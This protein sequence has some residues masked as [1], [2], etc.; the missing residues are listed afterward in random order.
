M[1]GLGA[2]TLSRWT[3]A[4]WNARRIE[5]GGDEMTGGIGGGRRGRNR[6]LAV[7]L[8]AALTLAAS[9]LARAADDNVFKI[10]WYETP[11]SSMG[12]AWNKAIEVWK[13]K[14]PGVTVAFEQKSWDQMEKAGALMLNSGDVPDVLEYNKGNAFAGVVASQGLLTDLTAEAAKRGWDKILTASEQALSRYDDRGI[15]GSGPL[16]GIPDYGEYVSVYYNKDM[17]KANGL[18]VPKTYDEFVKVMDA[19]VAKGITPVAEAAG[20]YP[21]VHLLAELQLSRTTPA[22]VQNYQALKAPFDGAP[23]LYAASTMLDWLKKGYIAKDVTGLK[24]TDMA[25]LFESGKSPMVITG[26]WYVGEFKQKVTF[27]WGQFLFP[28][29][30]ISS[31]STGN[32][33]VVPKSSKHKDWAYD[34][35]D[36]TLSKENQNILGNAGGVPVAA[37]AAAITDPIAQM[38][39]EGFNTLAG[40]NGLGFYPDW[41]TAGYYEVLLH[42]SQSLLSGQSTP[43]KFVANLAKPY[44]EAQ[45][46]A[47]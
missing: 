46:E 8:G 24:A 12:I 36:I 16:W 11:N 15:F 44:N 19:F 23:F 25:A 33:W 34:F 26:T 29:N 17:F 35:I 42:E 43:D 1:A 39:I 14:H 40:R 4:R 32:L 10:W 41:P 31:G 28:G 21:I 37:D 27:D 2:A 38:S 47:K 18:A 5:A 6:S 45:A 20:D 13:A 9:G 22:W 3:G 7:A 30:T